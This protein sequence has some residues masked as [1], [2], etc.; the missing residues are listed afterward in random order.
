MRKVSPSYFFL[1]EHLFRPRIIEKPA[2]ESQSRQD[3]SDTQDGLKSKDIPAGGEDSHKSNDTPGSK[4]NAGSNNGGLS[5]KKDG[6]L[7]PPNTAHLL[8][9]MKGR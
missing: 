1:S 5:G 3:V 7:A 4:D 6:L 8:S 9:I 2:K